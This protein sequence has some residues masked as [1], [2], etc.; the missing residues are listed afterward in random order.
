MSE[1]ASQAPGT[2][3]VPE[4]MGCPHSHQQSETNAK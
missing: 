3:T 1:A 4:G 2:G